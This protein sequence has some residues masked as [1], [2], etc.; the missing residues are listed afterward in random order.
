MAEAAR[1]IS[2]DIELPRP[3]L[4]LLGEA[5]YKVYYGGRGG[6]KSWQMARMLVML[7]LQRVIRILCAREFQSSIADSVHKLLCDQISALGLDAY[8][9]ITQNRIIS[10]S[11][12]EFV[13]KGLRRDIQEIK[14]TEELTAAWS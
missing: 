11:G 14:S 6:A 8:F 2:V 1:Q 3:F 4:P 7:S 12:S 5:R 10:A 13:F 9:S